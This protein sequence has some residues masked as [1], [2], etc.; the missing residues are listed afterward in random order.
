MVRIR[1]RNR[2]FFDVRIVIFTITV[3]DAGLKDLTKNI[4]FCGNINKAR[5]KFGKYDANYGLL[6]RGDANGTFSTIPQCESGF[7]LTGDVRSVLVLKD[8]VLFGVN[9]QALKAYKLQH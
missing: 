6:L 2:W 7:R 4:L 5:L 9:Q 3:L 1:T 8:K